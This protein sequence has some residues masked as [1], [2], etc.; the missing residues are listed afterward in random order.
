MPRSIS[1]SSARAAAAGSRKLCV[2]IFTPRRSGVLSRIRPGLLRSAIVGNGS[3]GTLRYPKKSA[4]L[5]P[6]TSDS[7][8]SMPAFFNSAVMAPD[9]QCAAIL[10][11]NGVLTSPRRLRSGGPAIP[12]RVFVSSGFAVRSCR[13]STRSSCAAITWKRFAT[14]TPKTS[15]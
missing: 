11:V 12:T 1:A 10:C 9:S 8:T 14:G 7:V 5:T 15:A 2:C 3:I 13:S 6:K 4:P